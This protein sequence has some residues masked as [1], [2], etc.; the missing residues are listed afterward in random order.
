MFSQRISA[1]EK[2]QA[3]FEE[4]KKNE[5]ISEI[6]INEDSNYLVISEQN[7]TTWTEEINTKLMETHLMVKKLDENQKSFYE[8]SEKSI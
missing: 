7:S 1:L 3:A 2:F 8:S 5:S 4:N 6:K